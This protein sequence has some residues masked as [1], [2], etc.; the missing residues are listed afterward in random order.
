MFTLTDFGAILIL[1]NLSNG[2]YTIKNLQRFLKFKKIVWNFAQI[3]IF[4]PFLQ[5]VLV[6]RSIYFRQQTRLF[7]ISE[8]RLLLTCA[9]WTQQSSTPQVE[10]YATDKSDFL[11]IHLDDLKNH[12]NSSPRHFLNICNFQILKWNWTCI[13]WIK[14]TSKSVSANL[15][16]YPQTNDA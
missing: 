3:S 11:Y 6:F 15:S 8:N 10:F 12:Q 9:I 4:C 5:L 7:L 1:L 16:R 2:I 13:N 14:M